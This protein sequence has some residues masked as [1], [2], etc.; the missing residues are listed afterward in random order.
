M[1][2]SQPLFVGVMMSTCRKKAPQFQEYYLWL[3]LLVI[4]QYNE[5]LKHPVVYWTAWMF[6]KTI[7]YFVSK[8]E[9]YPVVFDELCRPLKSSK[10]CSNRKFDLKHEKNRLLN[11]DRYVIDYPLTNQMLVSPNISTV[12]QYNL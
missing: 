6:E 7:F 11:D 2:M 12:Q 9:L 4:S 5:T 8:V 10:K 3:V 1:I